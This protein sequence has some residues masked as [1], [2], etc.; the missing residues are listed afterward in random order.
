MMS[1]LCVIQ[2][3]KTRLNKCGNSSEVLIFPTITT[4]VLLFETFNIKSFY[5]EFLFSVPLIC[6][7]PQLHLADLLGGLV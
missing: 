3:Y 5:K 4:S 2:K 6:F 7:C 1:V